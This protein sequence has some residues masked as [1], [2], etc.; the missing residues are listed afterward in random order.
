MLGV[1]QLS[2]LSITG[3]KKVISRA[4]I[5]LFKIPEFLSGLPGNLV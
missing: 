1:G 5:F 4:Y 2:E 3:R